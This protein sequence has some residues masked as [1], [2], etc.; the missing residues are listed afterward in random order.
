V[1]ITAF[2]KMDFWAFFI[3]WAY[4]VIFFGLISHYKLLTKKFETKI[5]TYYNQNQNQNQSTLQTKTKTKTY[6]TEKLQN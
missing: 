2:L 3:F 6:Y 5:K 1:V 4:V